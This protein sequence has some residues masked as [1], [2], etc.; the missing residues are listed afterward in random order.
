[1]EVGGV[2][3]DRQGTYVAE[4]QVRLFRQDAGAPI[5]TSTD[6]DGRFLFER[7]A[8]GSFLLQI[9]KE[10]FQSAPRDIE[11]KSRAFAAGFVRQDHAVTCLCILTPSPAPHNLA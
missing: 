5:R 11:L 8:P 3:Q 10:G 9:D 6:T 1:M 2:V 4:A 7:L